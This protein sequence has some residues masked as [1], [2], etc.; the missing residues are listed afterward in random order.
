MPQGDVCELEV[1]L[2]QG[3]EAW[4]DYCLAQ[5]WLL[6]PALLLRDQ[7]HSEDRLLSERSLHLDVSHRLLSWTPCCRGIRTHGLHLAR[8]QSQQASSTRTQTTLHTCSVVS[9]LAP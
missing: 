2:L 5:E 4:P 3:D 9:N 6:W 8:M 7:L 1:G